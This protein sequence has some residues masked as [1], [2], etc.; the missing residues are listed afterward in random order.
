RTLPPSPVITDRLGRRES[1]LVLI[2]ILLVAAVCSTLHALLKPLWFDEIITVAVS[3]LPSTRDIWRALDD[4]ADTNPPGIY[5]LARSARW[6]VAD[7]PLAPR[8]PSI[9][10]LL[11]AMICVFLFLSRRV[12]NLSA[13]VG[14]AFLLGTP[15]AEY[16]FEARPYAAMIACLAVAMVCWQ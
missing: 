7:D 2:A 4:A 14:S 9:A 12:S 13:L 3:G 11:V 8:L 10:G 15:L 6:F 5:L 1:T 16:A